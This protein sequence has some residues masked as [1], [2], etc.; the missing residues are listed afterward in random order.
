VN[1]VRAELGREA[2]G[3]LAEVAELVDRP[4]SDSRAVSLEEAARL[5]GVGWSSTLALLG[6]G[7]VHSV[8]V[9]GLRTGRA[10]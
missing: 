2:S 4:R 3:V 1:R 5:L 10:R 9:G 6:S 7:T 8:N